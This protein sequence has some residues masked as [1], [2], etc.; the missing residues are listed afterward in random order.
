M[1]WYEAPVG[2]G[3]YL[4]RQRSLSPIDPTREHHNGDPHVGLIFLV[5]NGFILR[6]GSGPWSWAPITETW[7]SAY[8]WTPFTNPQREELVDQRI[9]IMAT[10]A[11]DMITKRPRL[12]E[13]TVDSHEELYTLDVFGNFVLKGQIKEKDGLA[14]VCKLLEADVETVLVDFGYEYFDDFPIPGSVLAMNDHVLFI[15]QYPRVGGWS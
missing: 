4:C 7:I 5:K 2:D 14:F 15:P 13:K 10:G 8:W 9:V 3:M 1:I 12:V 11:T 6:A